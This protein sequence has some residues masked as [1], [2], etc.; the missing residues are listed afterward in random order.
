MFSILGSVQEIYAG[1]CLIF[2]GRG[3]V[4][5]GKRLLMKVGN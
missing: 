2:A 4:F 1:S 5:A 3:E